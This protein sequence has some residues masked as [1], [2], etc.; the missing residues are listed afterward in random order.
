MKLY[1][2]DIKDKKKEQIKPHVDEE[3]IKIISVYFF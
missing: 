3:F 1:G 2:I